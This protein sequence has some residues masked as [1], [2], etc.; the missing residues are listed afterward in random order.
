MERLVK[1]S[2]RD[3]HKMRKVGAKAPA[4]WRLAQALIEFH[5]GLRFRVDAYCPDLFLARLVAF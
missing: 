2:R 1:R 3:A 4:F 5:I